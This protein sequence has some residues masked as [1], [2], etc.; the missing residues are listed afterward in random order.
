MAAPGK[1]DYYEILGVPRSATADE[2]KK[3]YR[4]LTRKYHPDANPGNSE[5]EAKFK[6]I[7]EANDVLS[8]PQ[9]K[10]QYDQFGFVG[11]MPPPPNGRL[12]SF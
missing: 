6:E 9:K 1:K 5:A 11:D 2:I 7:N 3:A 4:K 8:D 10:A 12:L